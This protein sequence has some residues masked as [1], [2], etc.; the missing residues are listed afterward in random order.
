VSQQG[1]VLS[2]RS[3]CSLSWLQRYRCPFVSVAS[4]KETVILHRRLRASP[5]IN[6]SSSNDT[7]L[8]GDKL[9]GTGYQAPF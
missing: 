8:E 2:R 5:H 4:R 3:S 7:E 1:S 6:A 9:N